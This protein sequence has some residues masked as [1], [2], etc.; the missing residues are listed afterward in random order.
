[1][2]KYEGPWR[3]SHAFWMPCIVS[4]QLLNA[5]LVPPMYLIIGLLPGRQRAIFSAHKWYN[6]VHSAFISIVVVPNL[7]IKEIAS[8]TRRSV[9]VSFMAPPHPQLAWDKPCKQFIRV[10]TGDIICLCT[11]GTTNRLTKLSWQTPRFWLTCRATSQR[12]KG[13]ANTNT[14]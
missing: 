2:L 4:N 5:C 3:W 12:S 8:H 14:F 10:Y 1:M 6:D 9:R 11:G 13:H 7:K